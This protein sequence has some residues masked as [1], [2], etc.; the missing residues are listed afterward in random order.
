LLARFPV[1]HAQISVGIRV[2]IADGGKNT[3]GGGGAIAIHPSG[4]FAYVS[5]SEGSVSVYTI[6]AAT[7]TLTF[8]G[9]TGT[10]A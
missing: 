5:N 6:N 7:G 8:I 10:L 4:K 2:G 1:I 9:T 3:I